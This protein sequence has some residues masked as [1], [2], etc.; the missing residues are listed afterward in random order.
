MGA[1]T[2]ITAKRFIESTIA[3]YEKATGEAPRIEQA[4]E[5]EIK[6]LNLRQYTGITG[7]GGAY[8]GAIYISCEREMLTELFQATYPGVPAEEALI[9]DQVGELANNL[10]GRAQEGL[11]DAFEISCPIVV[12]NGQG[13]D[14]FILRKPIYVFQLTWRGHEAMLGL[15]IGPA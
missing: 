11:T 4:E 3:F 9:L 13:A 14:L 2:S 7:I 1:Q 6:N 8:R 10:A 5:S 12:Q 15:G